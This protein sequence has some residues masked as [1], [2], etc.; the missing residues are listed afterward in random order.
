MVKMTLSV[1]RRI[2]LFYARVSK[3][4]PPCREAKQTHVFLCQS[5]SR[6]ICILELGHCRRALEIGSVLGRDA[7]LSS[8][9]VVFV[10]GHDARVSLAEGDLPRGR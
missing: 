1:L 10:M 4:L 2:R 3:I 9:E 6:R 5:H 8:A 7:V